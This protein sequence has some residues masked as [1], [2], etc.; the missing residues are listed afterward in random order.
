MEYGKSTDGM[1]TPPS[2]A[3]PEKFAGDG[4]GSLASG[5]SMK[6]TFVNESPESLGLGNTGPNQVPNGHTTV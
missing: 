3:G 2:G 1:N 5:L 6:A 4:S